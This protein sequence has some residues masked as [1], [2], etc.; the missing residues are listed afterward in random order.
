[1]ERVARGDGV[2]SATFALLP[3]WISVPLLLVACVLALI[4]ALAAFEALKVVAEMALNGA[5]HLTNVLAA[6]FVTAIVAAF[7]GCVALLKILVGLAW[8]PLSILW[9]HTA[10]RALDALALKTEALRQRQQLW[11]YWRRE[12]R[13]QFP[14][15]REFMEAFEGGG[16]RREEP[17]FQNEPRKDER[18]QAQ[19]EQ[20]Q[21]KQEPPRPPPAP[22]PDP[23]RA[24][25]IAACRLFGLPETGNFT[26][27][28]LKARYR[29]LISKAH[30]DRPGYSGAATSINVAR[31]VIKQRKG[32]T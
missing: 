31:E 7:A 16:E 9:E 23:Q 25:F 6:I 4:V 13:D 28:D 17:Q 11:H 10:A 2:M 24:A 14:T 21:R 27:N 26:L 30:P 18:E 5:L 3:S 8:W 1:M 15:F 19:R 12:F 32:W 22:P 29:V 20:D